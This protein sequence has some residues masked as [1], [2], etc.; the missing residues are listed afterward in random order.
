MDTARHVVAVIIIV[1]F[2]PAFGFWL[3]AHPFMRF[4]RSLGPGLSYAIILCACIA[5]G[6]VTY[7]L[8]DSLLT[9]DYGTVPAFWPLAVLLYGLAIYIE[10]RVRRH[11][12]RK[13]LL[14]VPEFWSD[15]KPGRLLTEGPYARVRHPR[16]VAVMLA[17]VAWSL[18][19]NYQAVYALLVLSVPVINLVAILE[20]RELVDRFGEAYVRYRER[21]PRFIP[22]LGQGRQQGLG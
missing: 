19:T 1:S 8:R 21:V 6:V 12:K 18:F 9:V 14:G 10:I 3:L 2:P 17:F 16:Y 5:G 15:T 22:R 7:R 4:W 11:L 13:I 20:E